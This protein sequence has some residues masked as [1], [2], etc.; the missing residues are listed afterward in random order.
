MLAVVYWLPLGGILARAD[1]LGPKVGSNWHCF[2]SYRV[3][4]ELL[5]YDDSTVDV[6]QLLL[7]LLNVYVR[8]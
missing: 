2:C 8:L 1:W 3:M 4:G 6:V 7:L 5:Q